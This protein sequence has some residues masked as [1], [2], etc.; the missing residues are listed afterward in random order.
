MEP[1]SL[2]SGTACPSGPGLPLPDSVS[3]MRRKDE[4]G[5][6]RRWPKMHPVL[7]EVMTS[8]MSGF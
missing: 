8:P 6:G 4:A 1:I 7:T 2:A 3:L 5:Q